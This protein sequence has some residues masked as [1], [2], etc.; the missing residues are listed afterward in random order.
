[1]SLRFF[2][3]ARADAA[4]ARLKAMIRVT[5]TVVRGGQEREIPL[6]ELVPGDVIRLAAGDM[7]PADVRLVTCKDLYV[8]QASLTGEPFP[9]EKA[10]APERTAG[11]P[12]LERKNLCFLGTSVESGSA[13]GVIVSTARETYLGSMAGVILRKQAATSFDRGVSQFTWLMIRFI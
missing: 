3:E 8:I 9:V 10:E 6:A 1:V 13:R 12:P 7:I 2:Q 4:A 11:K 5:A